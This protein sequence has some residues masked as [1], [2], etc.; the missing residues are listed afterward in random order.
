[1]V[2]A[3]LYALRGSLEAWRIGDAER[4]WT[5]ARNL[6]ADARRYPPRV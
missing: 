5:G 6:Y 4:P 3:A 1:M 2:R